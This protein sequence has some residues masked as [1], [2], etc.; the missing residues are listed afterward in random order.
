MHDWVPVGNCNSYVIALEELLE[1][2]PV[3][4]LLL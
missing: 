4:S 2:L 1:M 3:I